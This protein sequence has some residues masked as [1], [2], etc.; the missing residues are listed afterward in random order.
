MP[1]YYTTRLRGFVGQKLGGPKLLLPYQGSN[2]WVAQATG[3][4][5]VGTYT[6]P[7]F[8]SICDAFLV[9]GG[10]GASSTTQGSHGGGGAYKR[11]VCPPSFPLAYQI[12]GVAGAGVSGADTTLLLPSGL[13]VYA[14]GGAAGNIAGGGPGFGV[15]GDIN[16]RGG[17]GGAAAT[18][19]A[20]GEQGGAGGTAGTGGGGGG[21]AGFRDLG[22]QFTADPAS[23]TAAFLP[24]LNG[25]NGGANGG[26]GGGCFW[27]AGASVGA[28]G[29]LMLLFQRVRSI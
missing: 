5:V 11:F 19:G 3:A 25:A 17:I 14:K 10:G 27:G 20:A 4:N 6:A 26:A 1:N 15:N 16:R 22:G 29:I 28:N 9:G 8:R 7:P 23:M 2:Q 13:T 24:G 18:A 12:A 21:G